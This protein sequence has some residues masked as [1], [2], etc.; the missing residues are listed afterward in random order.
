[1]ATEQPNDLT[2]FYQFMGEQID[3]GT[4]KSPED[5]LDL[6]RELH[7]ADIEDDL[8]VAAQEAIDDMEAGDQG[9][10]AAEFFKEF[11]ERFG[12]KADRP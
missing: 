6:W 7:P 10:P 8:I 12:I 2:Q 1:M 4:D 5:L 11:R 9:I 3:R